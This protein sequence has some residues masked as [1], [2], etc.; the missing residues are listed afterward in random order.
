MKR[1][2]SRKLV[3]LWA[4]V[5]I[6]VGPTAVAAN[7][8]SASSATGSPPASL[9]AV[10]PATATGKT[11]SLAKG[12]AGIFVIGPNGHALYVFDKDKGTKTACTGECATYWPAITASGP[13]PRG[14][15]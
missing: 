15:V 11:I 2:Q 5:V 4:S 9:K 10:G 1:S 12:R 6:A 8:A 14:P 13:A 7:G 3:Q